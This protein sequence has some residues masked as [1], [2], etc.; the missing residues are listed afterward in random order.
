MN[1]PKKAPLGKEILPC[2]A[3]TCTVSTNKRYV[4]VK[5]GLTLVACCYKHAERGWYNLVPKARKEMEKEATNA[6]LV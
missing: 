4:Y 1:V 2:E 5:G 6:Q 3:P